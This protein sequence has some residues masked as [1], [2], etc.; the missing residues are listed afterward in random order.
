MLD[1]TRRYDNWISPDKWISPD[2]TKL[3]RAQKYVVVV[4]ISRD[5]QRMACFQSKSSGGKRKF[6]HSKRS[7]S[8]R[9]GLQFPVSRVH[10]LLR[11]RKCTEHIA[12]PGSSSR[13]FG[14]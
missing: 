8:S 6:T 5:I 13:V 14:R 2:A 3:T 10:R 12:L 4:R 7:R 1:L 11:Q 9:A